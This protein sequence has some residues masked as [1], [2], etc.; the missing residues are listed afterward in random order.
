MFSFD[1]LRLMK[2]LVLLLSMSVAIEIQSSGSVFGSHW[3]FCKS[4]RILE[5]D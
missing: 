3:H 1:G 5:V 2:E 4:D